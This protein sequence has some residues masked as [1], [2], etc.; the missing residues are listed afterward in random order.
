MYT[1]LIIKIIKFTIQK[2]D[3][4]G[5]KRQSGF[6]MYSM[7]CWSVQRGVLVGTPWCTL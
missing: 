2:P 7:V 6:I 1:F 3:C 5:G 4:R